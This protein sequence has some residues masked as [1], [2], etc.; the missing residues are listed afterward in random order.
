MK[1]AKEAAFEGVG[2]E[3][4]NSSMDAAKATME[5]DKSLRVSFSISTKLV[6]KLD[7]TAKMLAVKGRG[8]RDLLVTEAVE[9]VLKKYAAG[10]GKHKL[11][12]PELLKMLLEQEKDK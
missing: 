8:Q 4:K 11:E 1:K 9:D 2:R 6:A 5:E 7:Y 3:R 12:N 10:Q